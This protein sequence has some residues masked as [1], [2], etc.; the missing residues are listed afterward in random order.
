M[1]EA[2]PVVVLAAGRGSRMLPATASRH[3]LL[4]EVDGRPLLE[5]VVRRLAAA[6]AKRAV[7]VTGHLGDQI[8]DFVRTRLSSA[9]PGLELTVVHDERPRGTLESLFCARHH[10][11]DDPFVV[12]EGA[13]LLSPP[14]IRSF[15]SP[16]A[17]TPLIG[18][19]T[20]MDLATG[21]SRAAVA[22][23]DVV[24]AL[25]RAYEDPPAPP[26]GGKLG[27]FLGIARL[28]ATIFDYRAE[29][30]D[31]GLGLRS[32]IRAGAIAVRAAWDDGGFRHFATPAE[33]G[34]Q[35]ARAGT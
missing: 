16:G 23:D 15:V 35:E 22:A 30:P 7:I 2:A 19:T 18:L 21:H 10:L 13:I 8:A 20:S 11:R 28:D 25:R 6:G 12:M 5:H 1:A 4:L 29:G 24:L 9:V 33:F 3:K 26:C 31:V 27:R 17:P 32:L 14:V 34:W